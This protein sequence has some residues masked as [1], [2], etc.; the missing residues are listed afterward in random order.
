MG[1]AYKVFDPRAQIRRFQSA[2]AGTWHRPVTML[3]SAARRR[4]EGP[5]VSA[6]RT[7][8]ITATDTE[9][10]TMPP[11][12]TYVAGGPI[13]VAV[14]PRRISGATT[15]SPSRECHLIH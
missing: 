1:T 7:I 6:R 2:K 5:R 12:G 8:A 13:G 9:G 11:K 15:R 10:D 4:C 14:K 3:G